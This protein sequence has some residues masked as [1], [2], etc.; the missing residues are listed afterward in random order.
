MKRPWGVMRDNQ[1]YTARKALLQI[2]APQREAIAL[3]FFTGFTSLEI[4]QHVK[5]PLH[6]VE[7]RISHGLRAL[8]DLLRK[9]GSAAPSVELGR[10][11]G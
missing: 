5:A 10:G 1:R 2:D 7:A 6:A 3:A 9:R 4:A 8:G 11:E